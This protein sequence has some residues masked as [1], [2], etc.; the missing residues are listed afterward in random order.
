MAHRA[1]RVLAFPRTVK[2]DDARQGCGSVAVADQLNEQLMQVR[3][4]NVKP[5][6]RG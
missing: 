5:A 1:E 2:Y 3:R 6:M 4:R